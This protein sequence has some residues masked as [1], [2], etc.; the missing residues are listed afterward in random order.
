[1]PLTQIVRAALS[2][3]IHGMRSKPQGQG[4]TT[5]ASANTGRNTGKIRAAR[6]IRNGAGPAAG[7]LQR[8]G[9]HQ[10][11]E[12]KEQIHR[13]AAVRHSA[14]HQPGSTANGAMWPSST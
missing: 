5:T 2:G 7:A 10:A 6:A 9:D 11:A 12:H 14:L 3:P 4:C 13:R 1:M 8:L